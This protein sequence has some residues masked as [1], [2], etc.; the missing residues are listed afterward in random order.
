MKAH[1]ENGGN[2]MLCVSESEANEYRHFCSNEL[3]AVV[4]NDGGVCFLNLID[5][6]YYKNTVYPDENMLPIFSRTAACDDES[7]EYGAGIQLYTR[8]ASG[9]ALLHRPAGEQRFTLSYLEGGDAAQTYQL[10]MESNRLLWE[11]TCASEQREELL[12]YLGRK[13][14]YHG[15]LRTH[16]DQH[17]GEGSTQSGD[18]YR[19]AGV[20][21]AVDLPELNGTVAVCWE[22]EPFDAA[23]GV[24]LYRGTAQYPYGRKT[25]VVAVGADAPIVPDEAHNVTL[26]RMPWE[27]RRAIRV[28]MAIAENEDDAVAALQDGLT[29]YA[30]LRKQYLENQR[31]RES[32][33]N[34]VCTK[35][36]P[37][38]EAYGRATAAYLDDLMVGPTDEGRIGVRAS[39]GKYGF[40][41][42]WDTIYPIRDLVWNG[43]FA[44]AARCL[45]YLF[46]LPAMENTPI[47]SL[48]LIVEW[49]EAMAFLPP[50]YQPE[51]YAAILKIFRFALR[52]T[53]PQYGL[54]LCKGNTGVDKTKQMGLSGLFLSP[55]VNA[56]WYSACRIVRNEAIRRGDT[57]TAEQATAVIERI[58]VGFRRVFFNESTGYFRAGANRDLSPAALEIHHNSLT[59]GYDYPYGM[60]LMRDMVPQLARYQSCELYH[61]F[62]HRAVAIDS[63]MPSGWW[64]FVH[65]NQHNGHEMKLQRVAGNM[66]EVYRV[67]GETMKRADRWKIAE[68]TTNFSRF[69]IHPDQVCDWQSFSATA[70]MEALRAGVAG[71]LRHRGGLCYLPA[72]DSGTVRVEG[73]PVGNY[74]IAIA[75]SGCGSFATMKCAGRHV[76]GTL[77]LPTDVICDVD[78]TLQICRTDRRPSY[79]VL[80]TAIDLPVRRVVSHTD[81]TLLECAGT[82]HTPMLW[83]APTEPT[84]LVNGQPVEVVWDAAAHVATVD[85][86]WCEGDR[87]ETILK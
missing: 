17:R 68:E 16:K 85:R 11:C 9:R 58:E 78:E 70:Q 4:D 48:H 76:K 37:F 44:D 1:C 35:A 56:L 24:L 69:A 63:P 2:A 28:G 23:R 33:A 65:M 7:Q 27:D 36:L 29:R 52:L 84:V 19:E 53:E 67:M 82:A 72:G 18:H 79:P 5:C 41:S 15:T 12:L 42:L 8:E 45:K 77:Q 60:Y 83:Q 46:E 39:A 21:L 31:L 62:G 81:R 66:A 30:E 74:R 54:L 43:R 32:N 80:L 26:L 38:A 51:V 49:N 86:L 73:V 22:E 25:Y 55:D 3:S 59:L 34:T 87:V 20:E 14:L 50:E 57:E 71:I 13:F 64:K 40:F 47:S 75:V 10:L 61:P 6:Y